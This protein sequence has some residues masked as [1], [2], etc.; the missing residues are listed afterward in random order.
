MC[1]HVKGARDAI[2]KLSKI[3]K[4]DN[5]DF[6]FDMWSLTIYDYEQILIEHY[7]K[8]G[9]ELINKLKRICDS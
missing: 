4:Q 1:S 8:I 2:L 9:L 5:A 3:L 6:W 7:E